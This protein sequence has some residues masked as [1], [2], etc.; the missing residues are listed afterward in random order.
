MKAPACLLPCVAFAIACPGL[1]G[2]AVVASDDFSSGGLSGGSGWLNNWTATATNPNPPVTSNASPLTAGGGNYLSVVRSSV[3]ASTTH[4]VSRQF[5]AVTAAS[6]YTVSFDWRMESSLTN[7][8]TFDD[9]VHIGASSG[10]TNS[11]NTFSWLL[12][13]A[14]ADS[15]STNLVP[16]GNWYVYNYTT[17]DAFSGDNLVDTG[18]KLAPQVTYSFVVDVIPGSRI[19]TVQ[20]SG[21]DGS[22]YTSGNLRFRN[23]STA[24][25]N[26]L[27]FGSVS[28][29][30]ADTTTFSFD[31][32]S[33][34][35]V[36]EP[37]SVILA[38]VAALAGI[39]VRRRRQG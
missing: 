31:N 2:A 5:S 28:H 16:D 11:N 25:T 1:A 38:G 4:A 10:A 29:S 24:A 39:G 32:V 8:T 23:N 13:V 15:G 14:A 30:S 36:P 18:I 12:G 17:N 22:A 21:S 26:T 3:T 35:G 6:P 19:Y 20:I 9:R 34:Q 7:F 33:I 27:V 37:G